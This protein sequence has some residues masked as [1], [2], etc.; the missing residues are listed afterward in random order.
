MTKQVDPE[1]GE[2]T[3]LNIRTS[4]GLQ[5]PICGFFLIWKKG[6]VTMAFE[7]GVVVRYTDLSLKQAIRVYEPG[8]LT[9]FPFFTDIAALCEWQEEQAEKWPLIKEYTDIQTA[10]VLAFSRLGEIVD[11]AEAYERIMLTA[12]AEEEE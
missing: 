1:W 5:L 4:H 3:D 7:S 2:P 10:S 8:E 11:M 12:L 9:S 6:V